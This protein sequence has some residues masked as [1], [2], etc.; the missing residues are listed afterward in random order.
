MHTEPWVPSD[1]FALRLVMVRA[2][3]SLS[4]EAAAERCGLNEKTWS[5]WER[6]RRP[7]GLDTVVRQIASGLGVDRGW[8]MFGG[9]INGPDQ[10][11]RES[12]CTTDFENQLDLF[13][14]VLELAG[15]A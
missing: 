3:L 14:D 12:P 4:Q 8:L 9:P 11:N 10:P 6:G 2:A 13:A 7:R 1:S 15:A 5:T